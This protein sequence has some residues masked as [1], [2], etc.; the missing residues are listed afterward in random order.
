MLVLTP[1]DRSAVSMIGWGRVRSGESFERSVVV[2]GGVVV[3]GV[4]RC[5]VGGVRVSGTMKRR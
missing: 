2:V 3:V 1:V 4:G 5:F